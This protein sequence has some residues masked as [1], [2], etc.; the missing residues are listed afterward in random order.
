MIVS[1]R[2]LRHVSANCRQ[3]VTLSN[4]TIPADD[5]LEGADLFETKRSAGVEFLGRDAHLAALSELAAVGEAGRSI[6]VY[7]R[8][9]HKRCEEFCGGFIFGYDAVR[10]SG[11][12]RID[13]F[14]G[15]LNAVDDLDAHNVIEKFRIKIF[16]PGC[17]AI[18][19]ALGLLIKPELHWRLT[20]LLAPEYETLAV[21][22]QKFFS[23]IF[24]DKTDF[25][26]VADGRTARLRILQY[27]QRHLLICRFINIDMTYTGA[28][29][30]DRNFGVFH[31]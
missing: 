30:E 14:D 9:I 27:V 7:C 18:D 1:T 6:D 22:R 23:D 28:R 20:R 25:C 3:P 31:T 8:R 24:V 29:F 13:V 11:G 17:G 5:V 19:D 26:S 16:R 21:F 10:M 2:R 12:M 4:L 15:I